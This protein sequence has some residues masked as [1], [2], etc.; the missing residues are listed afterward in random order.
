V[1]SGISGKGVFRNLMGVEWIQV[2]QE[3]EPFRNS[4]G[5]EWI[6]VSQ[7]REVFLRTRQ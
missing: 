2:S 1:D 4:M 6:Q 5:V 3:R 7:E